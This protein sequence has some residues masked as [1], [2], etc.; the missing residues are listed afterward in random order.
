MSRQRGGT[1]ARRQRPVSAPRRRAPGNATTLRPDVRPLRP[2]PTSADAEGSKGGSQGAAVA[3]VGKVQAVDAEKWLAKPPPPV[4]MTRHTHG[5]ASIDLTL[6]PAVLHAV[7]DEDLFRVDMVAKQAITYSGKGDGVWRR[8][9]FPPARWGVGATNRSAVLKVKE[10]VDRMLSMLQ[11][12]DRTCT[13][14]PATTRCCLGARATAHCGVT[15]RQT[16]TTPA[17]AAPQRSR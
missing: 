15:A 5:A 4:S 7:V 12:R 14:A 10:V 1:Q 2:L 17:A 6:I 3:L 8:V 9:Q 11:V 13:N 16:V